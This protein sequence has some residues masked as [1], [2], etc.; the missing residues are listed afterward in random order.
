MALQTTVMSLLMKTVVV[1]REE[2]YMIRYSLPHFIIHFLRLE[3]L[4]GSH[5]VQDL[6]LVEAHQV[7]DYHVRGPDVLGDK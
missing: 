5:L 2:K 3:D 6:R 7:V 1:V 4:Q